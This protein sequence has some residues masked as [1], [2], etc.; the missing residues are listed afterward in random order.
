MVP[1][2]ST[3]PISALSPGLAKK[4][5]M[6]CLYSTTVTSAHST[7]KTSIRTRKIRGEDNLLSSTSMVERGEE[8]DG[9]AGVIRC[10]SF[11]PRCTMAQRSREKSWVA[12]NSGGGK[13]NLGMKPGF[14][15]VVPD[16]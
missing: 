14:D 13:R 6:I 1:K 2:N 12:P 10:A 15:K 16:F 7:R 9:I 11:G 4:A 5:V 3:R 8:P